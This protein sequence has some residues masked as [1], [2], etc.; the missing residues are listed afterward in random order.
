M[1]LIDLLL[2]LTKKVKTLSFIAKTL[3]S[4]PQATRVTK[5]AKKKKSIPGLQWTYALNST[6]PR[7]KTIRP[8]PSTNLISKSNNNNKLTSGKFI[9][10]TSFPNCMLNITDSFCVL[11]PW[12]RMDFHVRYLTLNVLQHWFITMIYLQEVE[13]SSYQHSVPSRP[14]SS[15][16]V[17]VIWPWHNCLV[18]PWIVS[19]AME[20]MLDLQHW[21]STTHM[22][23]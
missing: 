8:N 2:W 23:R 14:S 15:S 6:H 1:Y 17:I 20:H 7:A 3:S 9:R 12:H 22:A 10:L 13:L 21:G 4:Q 11:R 16:D 18:T 5:G 19:V